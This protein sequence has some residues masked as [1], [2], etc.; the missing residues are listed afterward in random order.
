MTKSKQQ[1]KSHIQYTLRLTSILLS[2]LYMIFFKI[3]KKTIDFISLHVNQSSGLK[4]IAVKKAQIIAA[5]IPV[6]VKSNIPI[7][8]P[9]IPKL[10]A[11]ANAP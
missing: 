9:I 10:S 11:L 3:L 2:T 1:Q 7:K 6:A 8:I 4:N 5:L